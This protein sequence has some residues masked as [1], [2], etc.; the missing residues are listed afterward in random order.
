[1]TKIAIV[2]KSNK[3][4]CNIDD[5]NLEINTLSAVINYTIIGGNNFLY[6]HD[7]TNYYICSFSI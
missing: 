7:E 6:Y 3:P 1:M 2:M 4:L 5:E